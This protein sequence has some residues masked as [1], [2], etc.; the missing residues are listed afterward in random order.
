M[1]EEKELLNQDSL[2]QSTR[3][4]L[5]EQKDDLLSEARSELDMQELRIENADKAVQETGLQLHSQRMELFQVNQL[6]RKSSSRGSYVKSARKV[7]L[8]RS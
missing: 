2:K 7:M 4:L 5:E 8:H 6:K 1:L 3:F